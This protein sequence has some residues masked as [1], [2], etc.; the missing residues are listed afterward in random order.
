MSDQN[1]QNEA[2]ESRT[3]RDTEKDRLREDARAFARRKSEKGDDVQESSEDS[4]PASD[5][6]SWTPTTSIGKKDPE[7]QG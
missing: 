3:R 4:F 1:R 6:P 2:D 5:S 7:E